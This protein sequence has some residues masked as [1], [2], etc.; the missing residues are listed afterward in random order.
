VIF[1]G[2]EDRVFY[3]SVD[4][5]QTWEEVNHPE[6]PENSQVHELVFDPTDPDKL[7]VGLNG[8]EVHLLEHDA[9][10]GG[11]WVTPDGGKTWSE[12]TGDLYNDQVM[13]MV[14][15]PDG[16]GLYIGTYGGGVFRLQPRR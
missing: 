9:M 12:L 11:V 7:H 1:V 8:A 10:R 15:T 14:I 5:G 6:W 16:K 13:A 4:R 3:K 2:G